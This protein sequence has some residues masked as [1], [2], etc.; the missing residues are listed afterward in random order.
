MAVVLVVFIDYFA[1][2]V[3]D[4]EDVVVYLRQRT[5]FRGCE[6][7]EETNQKSRVSPQLVP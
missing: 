6:E 3:V 7:G 4:V 5:S 2:V 1:V